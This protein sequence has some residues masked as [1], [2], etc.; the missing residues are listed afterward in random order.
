MSETSFASSFRNSGSSVQ[1]EKLPGAVDLDLHGAAAARD[2]D[3]LGVEL[4]LQRFDAALH[5]L[6]LFDEFA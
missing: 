6:R 1:R 4:R 5:F 2:F 3:F